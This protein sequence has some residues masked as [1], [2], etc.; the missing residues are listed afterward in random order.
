MPGVN[1]FCTP[2]RLRRSPGIEIPGWNYK[3][4]L[5]GLRIL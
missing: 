4:R 1:S 3:T 2:E 5:R